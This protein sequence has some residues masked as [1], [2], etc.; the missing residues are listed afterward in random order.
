[1]YNH[2]LKYLLKNDPNE[3]I[4]RGGIIV[5]RL[6]SPL[7]RYVAAPLTTKNKLVIERRKRIPKGQRLIFASTHGFKD[8]I[9]MAMRAAGRHTYL[10][11]GSLPDFFETFHGIA[12]WLSGVILVDRSDRDSRRAA[13]EK[14]VRALKLG[15]D[16]LMFPEGVWNKS[17]NQIMLKLFPGVY[18]VAAETGALIVPIASVEE[19]GRVYVIM[20]KAFDITR[21]SKKE[22]LK[23]LRDKMS[24][25][26][27][28][29]MEKYAKSKR[30]DFSEPKKYWYDFIESLIATTGY[31][32]DRA[33]EDRAHFI[34]KAVVDYESAFEHLEHI[35]PCIDNA[36][37]FNSHLK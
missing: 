4:S 24:A 21:Y 26:K 9:T 30:S 17:P 10:L 12:L 19:H 15:A 8:D 36:F 1:M 3:V 6:F 20:E 11:Y 35:K 14:M 27:Y 18:D 5:R 7:L 25:A 16:I 28:E 33:V 31:H 32:Y 29:L 37:L 22:G 23:I 34:D 2:P 13:K